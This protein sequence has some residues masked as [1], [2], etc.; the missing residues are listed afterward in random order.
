MDKDDKNLLPTRKGGKNT[1]YD[2]ADKTESANKITNLLN[3]SNTLLFESIDRPKTNIHDLTELAESTKGYFTFCEQHGVIPSFRRLANWYGYSY[4][5][6][7]RHINNDTD[8]GRFLDS[9]RDAI[10]DNL[11]QAALINAVNNISAMFILKTQ[12]DYVEA[13]KVILEP[14]ESLLGQPKSVEEIVEYIDADIVED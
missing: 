11:E 13:T 1:L 10:K 8:T 4:K 5:Q 2:V 7:Y 14:S 6:L 9:V 3:K 12:H